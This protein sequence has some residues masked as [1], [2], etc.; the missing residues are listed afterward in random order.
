MKDLMS[1]GPVARA[2][3]NNSFDKVH[4]AMSTAIQP[5]IQADGHVVYRNKFRV[6]I[7]EK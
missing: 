6:V 1:A 2:I 7:A 3:E 5:Y 4:D